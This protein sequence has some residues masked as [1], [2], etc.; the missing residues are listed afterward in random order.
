MRSVHTSASTQL[1]FWLSASLPCLGVSSTFDSSSC[2]VIDSTHPPSW[3]AFAPPALPG[4]FTTTPPLTSA[5]LLP[6][7]PFADL[8][9]LRHLN[10]PPFHLQP[11][12]GL[13]RCL[14]HVTHQ[15]L[16]HFC[17]L[18]LLFVVSMVPHFQLHFFLRSLLFRVPL[19]SSLLRSTGITRLLH[20]YAA[21]DFCGSLTRPTFRRPPRFTSLE[22]P[23]IP[24]PTTPRVNKM[25]FSRP[26]QVSLPFEL[27]HFPAGSLSP[28]SRIEFVSYRL[29]VL[30]RLLPTPPHDD[31]VAVEYG[32]ENVC[33]VGTFTLL[34]KCAYERTGC[35]LRAANLFGRFLDCHGSSRLPGRS[36]EV[37]LSSRRPAR[38]TND[39][40]SAQPTW[41]LGTL[42][43]LERWNP[44]NVGTL[45]RSLKS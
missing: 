43:P 17:L 39:T 45:E 35:G 5:G 42:E 16:V 44:W 8:L 2:F 23:T 10:F 21:S 34:F 18:S 24:S 29:V 36:S 38:G 41:N 3:R 14:F 40:T 15:A 27:R 33:P 12:Q 32:P 25:P 20:Y 26:C 30:L 11:P 1:H 19:A 4:F 28:L 37:D 31:A 7:R 22:L 6:D 9:A 13:T